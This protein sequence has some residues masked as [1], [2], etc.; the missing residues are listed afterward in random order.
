[1]SETVIAILLRPG[2]DEAAGEALKLIRSRHPSAN[3]VLLTSQGA[4]PGLRTL[5]DEVWTDGAAR[6]P[7][8]FLALVRRLAW[9]SPAHIY[10]LEAAGMTRF[11]RL[12]VWPRPKWH[13]RTAFKGLS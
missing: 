13:S 9:A 6:G 3:L 2:G 8:R 12:C 7:S 11:M 4:A 10:D 1:M 5:A